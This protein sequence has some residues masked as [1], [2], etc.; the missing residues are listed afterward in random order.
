M[1]VDFKKYLKEGEE[2]V[3]MATIRKAV[4]E[5]L[6]SKFADAKIK[7]KIEPVKDSDTTVANVIVSHSKDI[8]NMD[9]SNA[10]A[11]IESKYKVEVHTNTNTN[12]NI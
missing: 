11:S 3:S 7:V 5:K 6:K 1:K 8:K 10:L 9:V 2:K 4:T 12:T